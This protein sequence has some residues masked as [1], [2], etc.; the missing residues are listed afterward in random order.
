MLERDNKEKLDLIKYSLESIYNK[1]DTTLAYDAVCSLIEDYQKKIE[2]KP[3]VM[4]EK[5]VILIN[6]GAQIFH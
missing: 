6:Y 4:T 3:Y 5:D 2:N 1:E